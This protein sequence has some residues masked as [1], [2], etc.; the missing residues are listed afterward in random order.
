MPEKIQTP[1]EQIRRALWEAHAQCIATID[2]WNKESTLHLWTV[3]HDDKSPPHMLIVQHW[4]GKHSGGGFD[5]YR[6]DSPHMTADAIAYALSP[7][8]PARIGTAALARALNMLGEA[9]TLIDEALTVHIYDAANGETP[10]PDC[11]YVV[12]SKDIA[13]LIDELK[14]IATLP[15]V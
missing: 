9:R 5:V 13:N 3:P 2:G 4:T 7:A 14:P 1:H 6:G 12:M 10:E 15:Q 11:Q 8:S